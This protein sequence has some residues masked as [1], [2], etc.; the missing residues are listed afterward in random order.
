MW[1]INN[2]WNRLTWLVGNRMI[3]LSVKFPCLCPIILSEIEVQYRAWCSQNNA[4]LNLPGTNSISTYYQ[5]PSPCPQ[6]Y[7]KKIAYCIYPL[8]MLLAMTDR[9]KK[10]R[11]FELHQITADI[12]RVE[13]TNIVGVMMKKM[14]QKFQ[15]EIYL[16][17][18]STRRT[19]VP[20]VMRLE[21][22]WIV[23]REKWSNIRNQ[24]IFY[25][26]KENQWKWWTTIQR[27]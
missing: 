12:D 16:S 15:K 26:Q 20:E 7:S 24:R 3:F 18:T 22:R 5:S 9:N 1:I 2:H 21:K 19:G 25:P 13:Y 10:E 27:Q 8:C 17:Q 23:W 6:Q 11:E 14:P 4:L